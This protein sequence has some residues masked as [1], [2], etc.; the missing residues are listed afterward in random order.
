MKKRTIRKLCVAAVVLVLFIGAAGYAIH[1]S[2]GQ[3]QETYVYKEETVK[4]GD[5]VSGVT[6]SGSIDL[7][8]SSVTFDVEVNEEDDSD[9]S[10]DEEEDDEDDVRY[11]E[12]EKV[13]VVSGQRICAGDPLFSITEKSRQSV[14]RKLESALA[15]KQITLAEAQASYETSA[16]E[17]KKTYETAKLTANTASLQKDASQAQLQEEINGLQEEISVL[18]LEINNCQKKL[19]DEDFLE[20]LNDAKT[21]C[22]K[23]KTTYDNTEISSPAAYSANYL[24]YANAKSAYEKLQEQKEGWEKTITKNQEQILENQESILKKQ[25]ILDAK[26][27]LVENSYELNTANGE[28]AGEIYSYTKESLLSSVE[29]AEKEAQEAQETLDA[30]NAFVGED[31]IVYAD[32]DGMVMDIYYEAGDQ[33]EQTGALLTYAKT[34]AYMVSVDV[35]EEDIAGVSIGDA[36]KVEFDAYPD[37]S[38]QGTVK[39]VTTTNT[40]TYAKTVSYPV[41]VQ[42]DGD[43]QKL[44]GGM[45]AQITFVSEEKDDTLYVSKKAIVKQDGKT[46]VYVGDGEEKEL[47]EVQTG[48]ENSTQIEITDGVSEGDVIYI[49]SKA[50]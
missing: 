48:F 41:F 18:E 4:R 13:Y 8:Q 29:S 40:S 6:E 11:L 27:Q 36:V 42:I 26:T 19:T 9:S 31:G 39:A 30:L 3:N 17:A 24:S 20:S 35:S 2:A 33:I 49:R 21:A 44:Y 43:T 10:S 37:E 16:L 1:A 22:E 23:A 34:D 25:S 12:I 5:I 28:L 15:Q 46:Y 50:G 47:K 32:G 14:V 38:Y 45:T 7:E